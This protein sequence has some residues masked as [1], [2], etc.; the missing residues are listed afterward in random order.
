MFRPL[1]AALALIL[2]APSLAAQP[3]VTDRPD[4]TES[5]SAVAPG[6]VQV[7]TG[8]FVEL[9]RTEQVAI[10]NQTIVTRDRT[11]SLPEALVRVGVV[12]GLEVR[13]GPPSYS[14]RR[15][16]QDGDLPIEMGGSFWSDP[17]VGLKAELGRVAGADLAVI[18][19]ATIPTS[20]TEQANYAT[21][22]LIL[23]G[24]ADLG[25]GLSLGAQVETSYELDPEYDAGQGTVGGTLVL[26][27]SLNDRLGTFAEVKAETNWAGG[28]ES[29][30]L[31]H[32]YTLIVTDD[33]QL[34]ASIGVGLARLDPDVFG[35]IG[36]SVRL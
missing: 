18:A 14:E 3:L 29:A 33:V 30:L 19:S 9:R 23:I 26:A 17:S 13:L 10:P 31:H 36:L 25:S 7:E 32:G 1:L 16:T 4:F 2:V 27:T 11:V 24:G 5:T 8:V 20:E 28:E 22:G 6:R 21:P 35:G 15:V 12:P 34:D